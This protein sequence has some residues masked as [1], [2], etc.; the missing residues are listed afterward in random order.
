MQ[1][2]ILGAYRSLQSP[3]WHHPNVYRHLLA[4]IKYSVL[5]HLCICTPLIGLRVLDSVVSQVSSCDRI[6]PLAAGLLYVLLDVLHLP[7][8]LVSASAYFISL[9]DET[10]VECLKFYD[11]ISK[12]PDLFALA[13]VALSPNEM[14]TDIFPPT[15]ERIKHK[16]S[17][18]QPFLEFSQRASATIISNLAVWAAHKVPLVGSI[19][20]GLISFQTFNDIIG[21]DRAV[22]L[23]LVIQVIPHR[24]TMA[25]MTYYWGS[26]NLC[27]DLLLPFFSRVKFTK[28]ECQQW[29]KSR[30]GPLLGFGAVYFVLINQFPW[31]SF[32]LFNVASGSMAY[33]LTKLSDAPPAQSNRLIDWNGSQ[34]LWEKVKEL[35][36][37]DGAFTDD[38]GF[39]AFPCSSLID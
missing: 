7:A 20:L 19:L 25:L 31:L 37:L 17:T 32:V 24:A 27:H 15:L 34:L 36:L 18:S 16:Y 12:R 10:F 8:V 23:F 33:L 1:L 22:I 11:S 35:L 5:V 29:M 9:P 2:A 6:R 4:S 28:R 30:G 39:A 13:L 3:H 38:E 14:G 21:T 26:R